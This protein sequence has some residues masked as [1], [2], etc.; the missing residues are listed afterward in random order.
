M[1][2]FAVWKCPRLDKCT[3]ARLDVAQLVAGEPAHFEFSHIN[4]QNFQSK[5]VMCLGAVSSDFRQA[6]CLEDYALK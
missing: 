2:V 5:N 3:K 6:F 4:R 1:N